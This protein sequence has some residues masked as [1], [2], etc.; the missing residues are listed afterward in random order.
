MSKVSIITPSYNRAKYIILCL[1]SVKNQ[2]YKNIQHIVIDG[3]STDGTTD[4]LK[5]YERIYNLKWISEP[6]EGMYFAINKG[7]D[8]A[9]GDIIAYL[10]TDDAYFPWSVSTAVEKIN[11]G[12]DIAYGDL[13]LIKNDLGKMCYLQFYR[14]FNKR[15]YTHIATLAQPTVFLRK[16][17]FERIGNFDTSYHLLGDCEF[18]LRC[19]KNNFIP[20]RI[21]EILALQIDH[22]ETLREKYI[23]LLKNEFERLRTDYNVKRIFRSRFAGRV[24]HVTISRYYKLQ[25]LLSVIGFGKSKWSEFRK[26]LKTNNIIV[27]KK[28]L[29]LSLLTQKMIGKKNIS[30]FNPDEIVTAIDK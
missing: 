5:E 14:N 25:Y 2:D 18:W 28:K 13:C 17:I 3:G 15:Y 21:N 4:I 12:Y 16:K 24:E 30:I 22:E 9:D 20:E 8:M 29:I 19:S 27:N 6:D 10:N 7:I 23:E 26:F 1:N 11:E